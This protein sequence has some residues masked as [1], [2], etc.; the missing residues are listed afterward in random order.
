MPVMIGICP[1]LVIT[2]H[3]LTWTVATLVCTCWACRGTLIRTRAAL[4]QQ[5]NVQTVTWDLCA[6]SVNLNAVSLSIGQ[7]KPCPF[8]FGVDVISSRRLWCIIW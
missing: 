5:N 6:V 7:K 2:E 1:S 4:H 8:E 3:V